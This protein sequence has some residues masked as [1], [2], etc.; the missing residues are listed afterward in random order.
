MFPPEFSYTRR[1]ATSYIYEAMPEKGFSFLPGEWNAMKRCRVVKQKPGKR[2]FPRCFP[3]LPFWL[4]CIF[5]V[6]PPVFF[7]EIKANPA[8]VWFDPKYAL[9]IG[10][11]GN[12]LY[13]RLSLRIIVVQNRKSASAQQSISPIQGISTLPCSKLFQLPVN[14][15][16]M[17][18]NFQFEDRQTYSHLHNMARKVL[19]GRT[20]ALTN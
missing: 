1:Y 19:G 11:D 20:V 9:G 5:E 4:N 17:R 18:L 2:G 16:G 6:F 10:K 3:T 8:F 14:L 12:A 13:Y 15:A 7:G